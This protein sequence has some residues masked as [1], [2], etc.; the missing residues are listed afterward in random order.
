[1]SATQQHDERRAALLALAVFALALVSPRLLGAIPGYTGA[2]GAWPDAARWL[3]QPVSWAVLVITGLA[4]AGVPVHAAARE[5][6]LAVRPRAAA[7]ALGFALVCSSPMLILGAASGPGDVPALKLAFTAGIWPLAEE[8]LF[9]GFALGQLVRRA[10]WRLWSAALVTGGVFGAAHLFNAEVQV[11]QLPGQLLSIGLIA[12]GGALFAWLYY[13]WQLNLWVA[14]GLHGFMNLW[15]DAFNMA[16]T[17]IGSA[18][19]IAARIAVPVIAIVFTE[20]LRAR[21]RRLCTTA[22]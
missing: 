21:I 16:D 6:G 14:I 20:V 19:V 17:P 5:L 15:F 22:R 2:V 3:V 13:R 12:I 1:M 8:V 7:A 4:L 9:R 11:H 18:G 10:R